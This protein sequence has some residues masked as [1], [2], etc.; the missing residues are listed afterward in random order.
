[1][2]DT[3][4]VRNLVES[5]MAGLFHG[6]TEEFGPPRNYLGR[7]RPED[8]VLGSYGDPPPPPPPGPTP[9]L[10]SIL[11][12]DE[13]PASSPAPR[14]MGR[15][16]S[17]IGPDDGQDPAEPAAPPAGRSGRPESL[18]GSDAD[19][20]AVNASC[21]SRT[22]ELQW[23]GRRPDRSKIGDFLRRSTGR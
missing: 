16:E 20:P 3:F 14:P 10:S 12:L 22:G 18:L 11:G 4:E 5:P 15:L 13:D 9:R 6:W 1:M 23:K 21:R 17:I 19:Q 2:A 8:T 7:V